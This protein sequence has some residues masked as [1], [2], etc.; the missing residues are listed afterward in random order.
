MTKYIVLHGILNS[1]I[2]YTDL[3]SKYHVYSNLVYSIGFA[4]L[5][6]IGYPHLIEFV[7]DNKSEES[8]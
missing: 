4:K 8:V 7:P 2:F 6:A 1:G 3:G 5:T